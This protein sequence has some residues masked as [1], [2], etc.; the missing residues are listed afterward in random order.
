MTIALLIALAGSLAA[1]A[2]IVRRLDQA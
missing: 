2:W 1:M